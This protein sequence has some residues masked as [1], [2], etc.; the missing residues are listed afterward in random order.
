MRLLESRVNKGSTTT[1]SIQT[2]SRP[3]SPR[4]I[5]ASVS[6]VSQKARTNGLRGDSGF[7][8]YTSSRAG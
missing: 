7:N 3:M 1:T 4:R 8:H 5:Q 2:Q 6:R